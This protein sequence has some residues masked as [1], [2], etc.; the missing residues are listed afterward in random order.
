MA[1]AAEVAT[2]LPPR[3]KRQ[4][5]GATS[6]AL[7]GVSDEISALI[8]RVGPSVVQV[9]VHGRGAGAGVVWDSD[10]DVLTNHHVV[11]QEAGPV[12]VVLQDGRVLRAEIARRH[13]T[14]DLALLQVPAGGLQ[15]AEAGDSDTLRVGELVFAIGHPWGHRDVVTAG[16]VTA[17]GELQ[18]SWGSRPIACIR[19]DVQLAPG[20]SGGPLLNAAGQVVGINSMILGG[21]LSVAIPSGAV[22][23]WLARGRIPRAFLG[24][25]LRPVELQ[26]R[27]A[28]ASGLL[29]SGLRQDGPAERAGLL[30][31]DILVGFDGSALPGP[32]ALAEALAGRQPGE[33]APLDVVR[34]GTVQRLQVTLGAPDSA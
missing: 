7:H 26:S 8:A 5:E 1:S 34:A 23:R 6:R 12:E 2:P 33:V 25:E 24:A 9:R 15:P 13:P 22:R 4:G 30:L 20:N 10:G 21:D 28:R 29:I 27:R 18:V 11:G 19:S 14:A 32:E 3:W 31:G 17:T 16:I